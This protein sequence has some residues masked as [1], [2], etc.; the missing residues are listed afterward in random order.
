MGTVDTS[1]PVW[2]VIGRLPE[3]DG[4][5]MTVLINADNEEA[6]RKA[7]WWSGM[8]YIE[9][10]HL[11][12]PEQIAKWE[13]A[14]AAPMSDADVKRAKEYAATLRAGGREPSKPGA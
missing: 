4:R 10:A 11:I 9:H 7:G 8:A 5:R 13:S 6:A 2:K 12:T 1:K 14:M 3:P